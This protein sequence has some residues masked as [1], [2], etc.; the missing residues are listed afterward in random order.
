MN[1]FLN[2]YV[3]PGTGIHFNKL[4]IDD[5]GLLS[6]AEA[7]YT[8]LRLRQ[9][10][11]TPLR[12]NF[13]LP[14]LQAIHKHIMQDVYSWAG[15]LRENFDAGKLDFVGGPLR[16]FT[17]SDSIVQEAGVLFGD[18]KRADYLKGL[19]RIEFIE[20]AA[21]LLNGIN[22]LHPFPEGNGRTQRQFLSQLAREA[23]HPLDFSI[24]TEHRMIE[25]SIA[26]F[27]GDDAPMTRLIAEAADPQQSKQLK[28]AINFLKQHWP[29]DRLNGVYIA[30][31]TPGQRYSGAL[32][33]R[34]GDDFMLRDD[35]DLILI[36]H[37]ADI[38]FQAQSGDRLEFMA[39]DGHRR[40]KSRA[41]IENAATTALRN[42]EDFLTGIPV[43]VNDLSPGDSAAGAVV[44]ITDHHVALRTDTNSFV[45]VERSQLTRELNLGD[46]VALEA[47]EGRAEVGNAEH[48]MER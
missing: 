31:T 40:E 2:P 26:G 32:V 42:R 36:G 4:G 18:L 14:H 17:P 29:P 28:T 46:V 47:M 20:E 39:T 33:G 3:D 13:D 34:S 45:A 24:S 35:H 11:E 5:P 27:E 19:P 44:A 25:A 1:L 48:G 16:R 12:G 30:S 6:E 10:E 41:Q 9:L 15:E 38:P 7:S 8:S 22:R 37:V 43:I 23:G 21:V